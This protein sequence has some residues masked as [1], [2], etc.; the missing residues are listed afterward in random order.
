[1]FVVLLVQHGVHY[2]LIVP[3]SKKPTT[4]NM[5]LFLLLPQ[6]RRT[7]FWIESSPSPSKMTSTSATSLSAHRMSWRRK[8]R[9]W[10]H[11]RL[12]LEQ[13]TVTGYDCMLL[14]TLS[15]VFM[16]EQ[17][18]IKEKVSSVCHPQPNQHNT[19]KS[20]TFQA[21]EKELVFDID[22]TDYDDVRSCCR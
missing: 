8:C 20:G 16:W 6:C 1:M 7:T 2:S 5:L 13:Y 17:T 9:R 18:C 4:L 3:E 19:V 21:L 14:T 15:Q 10:T 22:M 12:T 11:T